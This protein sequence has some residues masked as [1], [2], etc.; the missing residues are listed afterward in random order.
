MKDFVLLNK[1][2]E[3]LLDYIR[4]NKNYVT[5]LTKKICDSSQINNL[6]EYGYI[7]K[8][9]IDIGRKFTENWQ[10]DVIITHKGKKYKENKKQYLI[11][12]VLDKIKNFYSKALKWIS[13]KLLFPIIISFLTTII[14]N[15][16]LN[17]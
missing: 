7:E 12:M 16:Y 10:C 15:Y 4:S 8:G 9:I 17:N 13:E 11:K 1:D 2:D 6:I 3:K 14:T 5:T